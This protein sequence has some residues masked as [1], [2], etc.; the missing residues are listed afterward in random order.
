MKNIHNVAINCPYRE[1]MVTGIQESSLC[2]TQTMLITQH[3]KT[4]SAFCGP[5]LPQDLLNK[6]FTEQLS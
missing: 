4:L 2:G 5:E 1:A 6:I 3:L